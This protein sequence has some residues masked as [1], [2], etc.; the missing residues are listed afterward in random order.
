MPQ[1]ENGE[2]SSA[3]QQQV[4]EQEM[5]E[6][7]DV[8]VL[9]TSSRELENARNVH[10]ASSE[11]DG[12]F[13]SD[14]ED[15]LDLLSHQRLSSNF[16]SK[17]SLL[18]IE[19][20]KLHNGIIM[21]GIIFACGFILLLAYRLI[22][23]PI[24][25]QSPKLMSLSLLWTPVVCKQNNEKNE[26]VNSVC[27]GLVQRGNSLAKNNYF[28]L[29]SFKTILD[30]SDA[31]CDSPNQAAYLGSD[32]PSSKS[33]DYQKL[34]K[35]FAMFWP[36]RNLENLESSQDE[37][38]LHY[39]KYGKCLFANNTAVSNPTQFLSMSVELF[40]Q[41]SNELTIASV[42]GSIFNETLSVDAVSVSN[43][44]TV[45]KC[46]TSSKDPQQQILTGV[47]ICLLGKSLSPATDASL[48]HFKLTCDTSKPI[49]LIPL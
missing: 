28:V 19:N 43:A 30:S 37:W 2:L 33:D 8:P 24:E 44:F 41:W 32:F 42:G 48:C 45:P 31:S 49:S 18:G 26:Y 9:A 11:R 36:N 15:E 7:G 17:N 21:L 20:R 22:E 5:L 4:T 25:R 46:V 1:R 29:T 47:D 10:F 35:N 12:L 23:K 16:D 38:T 34:E 13:D 6:L 40:K 14:S 3:D 39:N 27:N